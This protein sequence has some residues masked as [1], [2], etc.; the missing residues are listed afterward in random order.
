MK[1]SA[2]VTEGDGSYAIEMIEIDSPGEGE[3]LVETKASGVCHTDWDS[4][5]W[6]KRLITGHEGAGVVLAIGDG[7]R[8]LSAG[9]RVML[10]WAIPCGRCFQC[11]HGNPFQ[12]LRAQPVMGER[13]FQSRFDLGGGYTLAAAE[14][15]DDHG[16]TQAH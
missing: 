3:V 7:V 5:R 4:L 10:N 8:D 16:F 14:S 13:R 12:L 15:C 11:R 9:Q 6:K 1:V 2:A